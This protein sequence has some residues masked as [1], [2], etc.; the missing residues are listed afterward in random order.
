MIT[1]TI[2]WTECLSAEKQQLQDFALSLFSYLLQLHENHFLTWKSG[3]HEQAQGARQK[4]KSTMLPYLCHEKKS[5]EQYVPV[6][7]ICIT[8]N[9]SELQLMLM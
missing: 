9:S 7:H 5:S 4:L 6:L 3:Q 1:K 2:K 8:V